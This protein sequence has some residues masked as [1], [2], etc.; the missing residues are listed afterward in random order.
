MFTVKDHIVNI[1][2]FDKVSITA[3]Q[4]CC[5]SWEVAMD[6]MK[7]NEFGCIPITLYEH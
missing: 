5:C 3:I 7:T 6:N 4:F 1:L 2:I